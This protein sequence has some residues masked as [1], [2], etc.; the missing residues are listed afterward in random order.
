MHEDEPGMYLSWD[1]IC[2]WLHLST[3]T[4]K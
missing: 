1:S 3:R 4:A 2:F